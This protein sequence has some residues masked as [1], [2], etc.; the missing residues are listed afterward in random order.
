ML[1]IDGKSIPDKGEHVIDLDEL[2]QELD[3]V[4]DY[5]KPQIK[6]TEEPSEGYLT[7]DESRPFVIEHLIRTF[8]EDIKK[9]AANLKL[10]KQ[11]WREKR[12]HQAAQA[13]R[14][15][16]L[17]NFQ[18]MHESHFQLRLGVEIN[19]STELKEENLKY[20]RE[21]KSELDQCELSER[22]RSGALSIDLKR[23]Y[24]LFSDG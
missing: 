3:E 4:D 15:W 5:V 2:F 11:E 10:S 22:A 24:L 19:D 18:Y 7:P 1:T 23:L 16:F 21:L 14:L 6:I 8:P 13:Y 9:S 20:L 17:D 12:N